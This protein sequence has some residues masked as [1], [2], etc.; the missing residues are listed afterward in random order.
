M[1]VNNQL[2]LIILLM[3]IIGMISIQSL[4]KFNEDLRKE[5]Q[6]L[7]D[8]LELIQT[9]KCEGVLEAPKVVE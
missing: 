6:H 4:T 8:Q 2:C 7:K 3:G 1:S 5:N 9:I